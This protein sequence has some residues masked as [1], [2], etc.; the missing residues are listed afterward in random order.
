MSGQRAGSPNT[1][2]ICASSLTPPSRPAPRH[3]LPNFLSLAN[4]F[5]SSVPASLLYLFLPPLPDLWPRA[6]PAAA[7]RRRLIS[8]PCVQTLRGRSTSPRWIQPSPGYQWAASRPPGPT[9]SG[10]APSIKWA[11]ASTALRLR[12]KGDGRQ[13]AINRT[14]ATKQTHR[15]VLIQY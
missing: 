15:A 13:C 7:S 1:K 3:P 6:C 14:R 11:G 5:L 2:S 4:C 8:V 10:F 12:G 9:S